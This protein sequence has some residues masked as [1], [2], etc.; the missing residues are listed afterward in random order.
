VCAG[1]EITRAVFFFFEVSH[2]LKCDAPC[3][4]VS[5]FRIF[6]VNFAFNFQVWVQKNEDSYSG[7]IVKLRKY[8]DTA[9]GRKRCT[10]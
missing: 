6:E 3:C 1:N 4:W 10:N 9:T 2:F 7:Q 8:I 5:V